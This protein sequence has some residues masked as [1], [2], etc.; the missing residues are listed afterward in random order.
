MDL[1]EV[2]RVAIYPPVGIARI[3][4]SPEHFLATE[5]ANVSVVPE[6]GFKDGQGRIKKEVAR[7][8]IYAFDHSNNVIGEI[9]ANETDIEWRVE[10]ANVKPAWYEFNNALDL[11]K[12]YAIP[13]IRRN[14]DVVGGYREQL[15]IK[16]SPKSISGKNVCDNAHN[17][18]DGKFYGTNVDLGHLQTDGEG[19]L[20]FFPGDGDA[21][22]H[23]NLPITTFANNNG[24]HDDTCDGVIRASVK[25]GDKIIEAKP[26][27]IAVTPPNFGQGL[28]GVVTMN[29]VVQNLFINEMGYPNPSAE[30]VEFWRDIYPIFERMTNTQWVNEGF[31]QLF[32]KNSPSDFTNPKVVAVLK[33]PTEANKIHRERVF[34]WFRDPAS[35]VP[36]PAKV[37][38]FYG[39]GFGNYSGI[40]LDDLPITITQYNRLLQWKDGDF[41]TGERTTPK[42][43]DELT[44]AEQIDSLNQAGLDDCL[45]GPFHPGIELTWTM[46]IKKMWENP[47]RLNVVNE[48]EA[49]QLDFGDM[50]TPEIALSDNGPLSVNGPGSLTR[51]MGVPWQTDESSC[52][53]GYTVS[54]YLPLPSFWAAR[55]PNQVFAEDGYLRIQ[56][57]NVNIAQRLKH[58]DYRQDWL[59]D[60]EADHLQRLQNMVDEWH[61]LGIVTKQDAPISNNEEG[62]LP[63]VSWVEMGRNFA[64]GE[65][66]QTFAQVLYAEGDKESVIKMQEIDQISMVAA[67]LMVT[68][69]DEAAEKIAEINASKPKSNR[70]RRT[71]RRDER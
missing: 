12:K 36:A 7:F 3:G 33:E 2:C 57:G 4:N 32:G 27:M 61:Q 46:R 38:P 50:L 1:N 44:P 8:R 69:L 55:V 15:A 40:S 53:S 48:G 60:I 49:I 5:Q 59:R 6:G 28:Y 52:L 9:T 24:W 11:G 67:K 54:N 17:F 34:E 23:D 51:W 16:P 64:E 35:T 22:S 66:D 18:D 25:I 30:G 58:L 56:A 13:S 45:G 71:M 68:T 42:P 31:Y 41:T 63:D 62:Y 14:S 47:Y 21:Q 70:K 29:D 19:R 43:F 37:P 10:V 65:I 26:S 20:L 39:D